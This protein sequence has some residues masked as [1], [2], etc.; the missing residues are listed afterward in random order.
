MD[1]RWVIF[2]ERQRVDMSRQPTH[3][4]LL[5]QLH[6]T[7]A[8]HPYKMTRAQFR[9]LMREPAFACGGR[10]LPADSYG[11]YVYRLLPI[12][13][14]ILGATWTKPVVSQQRTH[15]SLELQAGSVRSWLPLSRFATGTY[16]NERHFSWWTDYDLAAEEEAGRLVPAYRKVG[17]LDS[18]TDAY[19]VLLRCKTAD[20]RSR[21]A[22]PSVIDGFPG[23][24][25]E[26][27]TPGFSAGRA[28]DLNSRPFCGGANEFVCDEIPVG[29]IDIR[30]VS[31]K[32]DEKLRWV[33]LLS[34]D[35]D[36]NAELFKELL[37]YYQTL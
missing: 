34:D 36:D 20:I 15:E 25:F 4:D 19:M 30:P 14:L 22:V 17:L 9:L 33:P 27:I 35:D 3:A 10:G 37:S 32:E 1:F 31:V 29:L 26:A 5:T 6:S 23:I 2:T 11:E 8:S 13:S 28:I 24:V 7:I 18:W 21:L 12:G 16:S